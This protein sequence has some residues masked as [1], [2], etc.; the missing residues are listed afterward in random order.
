MSYP[1]ISDPSVENQLFSVLELYF[2]TRLSNSEDFTNWFKE[3]SKVTKGWKV[4]NTPDVKTINNKY[5]VPEWFM[6][7]VSVTI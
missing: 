4:M 6:M 5:D 2:T 1:Q 3:I 7:A